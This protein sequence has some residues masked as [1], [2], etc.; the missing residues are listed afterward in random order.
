MK[1]FLLAFTLL[2]ILILATLLWNTYQQRA[3]VEWNQWIAKVY[4]VGQIGS[5]ETLVRQ[6]L[7]KPDSVRTSGDLGCGFSPTPPK[8]HQAS[9]VYLYDKV[10]LEAGGAW[11]TYVYIGKQGEV[12]QVHLAKS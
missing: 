5:N 7:G 1:C 4:I 12:L 3:I 10:F 6:M 8:M 2:V 11:R 9:K